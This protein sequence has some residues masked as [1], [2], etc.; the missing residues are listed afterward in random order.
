MLLAT[1]ALT[2]GLA[3]AGVQV[4]A[5]SW[6]QTPGR[7]GPACCTARG[8]A[9]A[10]GRRAAQGPGPRSSCCP[11]QPRFSSA[12]LSRAQAFSLGRGGGSPVLALAPPLSHTQWDR[13]KAAGRLYSLGSTPAGPEGGEP[14]AGVPFQGLSL[15]SGNPGVQRC[16]GLRC[17]SCGVGSGR[18]GKQR[19]R[20]A[21]LRRLTR[22][23]RPPGPRWPHP[24]GLGRK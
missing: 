6:A 10:P 14:D 18:V 9:P 24:E 3:Q 5:S 4:L 11:C 16:R 23:G 19:V 21:P 2:C 12:A 20:K 22:G 13:N 1:V 8:P 15:V 7:L 17:S